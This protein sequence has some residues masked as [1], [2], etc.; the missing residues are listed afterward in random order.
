MEKMEKDTI[1]DVLTQR[2]F[3]AYGTYGDEPDY[4][5]EELAS[6]IND[7]LEGDIN[8]EDLV[9]RNKDGKQAVIYGDKKINIIPREDYYNGDAKSP[10]SVEAYYGDELD[11]SITADVNPKVK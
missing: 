3:E 7:E 2:L 11:G 5:Y 10:I 8:F 6:K 1:L 4:Y 9:F